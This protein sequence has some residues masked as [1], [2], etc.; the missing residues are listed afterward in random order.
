MRWPWAVYNT[1]THSS[2]SGLCWADLL[3]VRAHVADPLQAYGELFKS[4]PLPPLMRQ[5]TV[6][7]KEKKKKTCHDLIKVK[8][9]KPR[10][11]IVL[12]EAAT[13]VYGTVFTATYLIL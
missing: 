10:G 4:T 12:L 11:H 6:R 8:F 2:T 3:V 7:S 5:K 13:I 1:V 9:E